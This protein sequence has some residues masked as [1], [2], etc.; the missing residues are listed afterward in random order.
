MVLRTLSRLC[1]N[2]FVVLGSVYDIRSQVVQLKVL[3]GSSFL[4]PLSFKFSF[5]LSLYF[6]CLL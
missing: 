2:A 4:L 1:Y 5:I 3:F 6:L